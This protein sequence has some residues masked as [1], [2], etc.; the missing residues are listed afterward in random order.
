[1][2]H[3][4]YYVDLVGDDIGNPV[5]EGET[6]SAYKLQIKKRNVDTSYGEV[7]F[8]LREKSNNLRF[9]LMYCFIENPGEIAFSE[10]WINSR[11]TLPSGENAHCGELVDSEMATY[12][13]KDFTEKFLK[14]NYKII[15]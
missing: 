13:I 4:E 9:I 8:L 7:N 3:I 14:K 10:Y 15:Q 11:V 6:Y 1:M 2:R 12:Y 5:V